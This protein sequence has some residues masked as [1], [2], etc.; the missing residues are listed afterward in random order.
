MTVAQPAGW[1][2]HP[3]HGAPTWWDG[4]TFVEQSAPPAPPP[5]WYAD[6]QPGAER[7]W[8]GARW[9]ERVRPAVQTRVRVELDRIRWAGINWGGVGGSAGSGILGG[10]FVL[11][12]L[13]PLVLAFGE[14][15]AWQAVF[16]VLFALLLLFGA[17]VLFVNVHFCRILERRGPVP[18]ATAVDPRVAR[19]YR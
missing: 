19:P 3:Q 10:L 15:E 2:P 13:P 14:D 12:G 9:T 17:A 4:A 6:A 11:L 18:A 8:D 5:G 1:Y 7:W 16:L